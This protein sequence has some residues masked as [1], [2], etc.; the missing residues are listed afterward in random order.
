MVRLSGLALVLSMLF[1]L[2]GNL[3]NGFPSLI[4]KVLHLLVFSF[5]VFLV[6]LRMVMGR[7]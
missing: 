4:I 5:F 6:F 3:V 7:A 2:L 1:L